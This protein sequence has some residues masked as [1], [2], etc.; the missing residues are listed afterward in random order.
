MASSR[1]CGRERAIAAANL[2]RAYTSTHRRVGAASRRTRLRAVH[3]SSRRRAVGSRRS[4]ARS[5][6]RTSS[7]RGSPRPPSTSR[8]S[9]RTPRA[10]RSAAVRAG[11]QMNQILE[12]AVG[13]GRG[14]AHTATEPGKLADRRGCRAGR[15]RTPKIDR[16]RLRRGCISRFRFSRFSFLQ[17][18]YV[19]CYFVNVLTPGQYSYRKFLLNPVTAARPRHRTAWAIAVERLPRRARGKRS[20]PARPVR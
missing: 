9:T 12:A 18:D 13:G 6:S 11:A 14:F 19:R 1:A 20:R 3:R 8:S 16:L 4:C 2:S 5:R 17:G 10:P 7:L 15:F